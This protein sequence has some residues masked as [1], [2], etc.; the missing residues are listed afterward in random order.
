MLKTLESNTVL[1]KIID[2]IKELKG[3]DIV[4]LDLSKIEN[5]ICKFFVICTGNS[6]T[7]AKAIED[8]I[9]RTYSV[10]RFQLFHRNK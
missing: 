3:M 2:S 8:K 1:N 4:L 6:N 7:H 10:R 5:A 9:R